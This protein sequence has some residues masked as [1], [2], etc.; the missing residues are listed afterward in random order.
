MNQSHK[1]Y[2]RPHPLL[3]VLL[4]LVIGGTIAATLAF[5]GILDFNPYGENIHIKNFS[6]HFPDI[7]RS[8]RQELFANLYK[9]VAENSPDKEE[10]KVKDAKIRDGSVV[11]RN[12][13]SD[14]LNYGE[15]IVDIQSLEQSYRGQ[16][17]WSP[18]A[19]KN[20]TITNEYNNL[21]TCLA[22]FDL[23]YDEF[24]CR[25]PAINNPFY[26]LA[27][28]YPI[29][30]TLPINV[31]KHDKNGNR[32]EYSVTY[33]PNSDNTDI[34]LVINDKTGGN[35]ESALELLEQEGVNIEETMISYVDYKAFQD[36]IEQGINPDPIPITDLLENNTPQTKKKE[37]EGENI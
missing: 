32:V 22:E 11:T 17:T 7:P 14:N 26:I 33:R 13:E 29:L 4:G 28:K 3:I 37:T 31:T 6:E 8:N 18:D 20:A 12:Y 25:N 34:T 15:F 27:G 19:E 9:M 1:S 24:G 36:L 10:I 35:L 30:R 23:K 16:F 21:I 5:T 2:P